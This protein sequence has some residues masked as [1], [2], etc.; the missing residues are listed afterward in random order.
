MTI[1]DY[2]NQKNRGLDNT[3]P[4]CLRKS[5]PGTRKPH[6]DPT[7]QLLSTQPGP[8]PI[9]TDP[10]HQRQVDIAD[11]IIDLRV[12]NATRPRRVAATDTV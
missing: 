3:R 10:T 9:Q 8:R 2:Q 7:E 6:A 12:T 4:S 5:T 1:P 11:D